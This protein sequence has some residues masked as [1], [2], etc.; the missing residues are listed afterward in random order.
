MSL[1]EAIKHCEK[2]AINPTITK[3]CATAHKQLALWLTHYQYFLVAM[4]HIVWRHNEADKN[5][6]N[7]KA[8]RNIVGD[9]IEKYEYLVN[10]SV[11]SPE[12]I[13][14]HRYECEHI[15]GKPEPEQCPICRERQ[16]NLALI[17]IIEEHD[18]CNAYDY[19]YK[20][21]VGKRIEQ[22]RHLVR[23]ENVK[24]N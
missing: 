9:A 7:H 4:E 24:E 6:F 5:M 2:M 22:Y 3:E 8:Y 16:L 11:E 12:V 13:D 21:F 14:F 1:N 17:K 20:R 23:K 19:D 18:D 10:D 15:V